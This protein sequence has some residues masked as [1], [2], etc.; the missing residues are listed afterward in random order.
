MAWDTER[1]RA[2]LL[3]A[4]V[5]EFSSHGP[6]GARVDRI[7]ARAGVN[8]ER[9]Y[10]YFGNKESLFDAVLLAEL[11]R[12]IDAVPLRAATP[13]EFASYVVDVF[14]YHQGH[15]HL[16]R[17]LYWEGLERAE[18]PVPG[19][20]QRTRRYQQKVRELSAALG[21]E[22]D[23]TA[24]LLLSV[25]ALAASWQ[26][27]PQLNRMLL[28]APDPEQ[29]RAHLAETVRR[30]WGP[31]ASPPASGPARHRTPVQKTNRTSP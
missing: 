25:I 21:R 9:I 31:P 6:S 19:E 10:Q 17:L 18:R 16:A 20:D 7:A 22:P 5:A 2:L 28:G 30:L 11:D 3:E 8:K 29:R 4:A 13:E 24:H 1:T 14:D 26:T 23:D 12:L 27:L 15:P